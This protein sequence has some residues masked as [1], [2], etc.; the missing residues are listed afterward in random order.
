MMDFHFLFPQG[1]EFDEVKFLFFVACYLSVISIKLLPNPMSGRFFSMFYSE[2][3]R[4]LHLMVQSLIH[5][6]LIFKYSVWWESKFIFE[7]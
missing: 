4:V 3:F 6:E 5:I 7:Y 2:S 1:L